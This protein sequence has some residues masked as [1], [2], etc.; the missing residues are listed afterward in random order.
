MIFAIGV[1]PVERLRATIARAMDDAQGKQGAR[2]WLG[3]VIL[4]VGPVFDNAH[5]SLRN[6][7]LL[8]AAHLAAP[9]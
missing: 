1:S 6:A 2:R 4:G 7:A 9:A 3:A 5:H 8:A